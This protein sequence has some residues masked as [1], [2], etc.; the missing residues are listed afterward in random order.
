MMRNEALRLY[1]PTRA[2]IQRV[3][4][5]AVRACNA[6]D[7]KRAASQLGV[8]SDA[9]I[10]MPDESALDMVAD[11][12]LFEPNQRGRRSYDRFLEQQAKD[13]DPADLELAERMRGAYFSIFRMIG[14]HELAGVWVDDALNENQRIWILD[15]GL[16]ASAPIGLEFGLRLFDAGQFHAGFGIVVPSDEGFTQLCIQARRRGERLPV[17]RSLAASLYAEAIWAETMSSAEL[18]L[19]NLMRG[20]R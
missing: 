7:W 3:L 16:E 9:R 20:S 13:L 17:R 11:L 14:R 5:A 4:K 15:E 12:G 1:R 10:E 6:A 19:A 18:E 2:G 8:W